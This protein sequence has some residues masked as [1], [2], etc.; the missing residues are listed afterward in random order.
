M[1]ASLSRVAALGSLPAMSSPPEPERKRP[2]VR[3]ALT[4]VP[5]VAAD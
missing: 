2:T 4:V 5:A 1:R 3:I